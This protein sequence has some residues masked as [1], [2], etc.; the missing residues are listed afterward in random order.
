MYSVQAVHLQ[1]HLAAS[2]TASSAL[3]ASSTASALAVSTPAPAT[4][5]N[6]PGPHHRSC[7]ELHRRLFGRHVPYCV[8]FLLGGREWPG[9]LR[10]VHDG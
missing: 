3:A 5:A 10:L 1:V 2:S 7:G 9:L 8:P 6:V 4:G